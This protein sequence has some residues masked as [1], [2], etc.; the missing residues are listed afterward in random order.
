DE[1]RKKRRRLLMQGLVPVMKQ[2]ES[3]AEIKEKNE[4]FERMNDKFM[5]KIWKPRCEA[6]AEWEKKRN[7]KKVRKRKVDTRDEDTKEVKSQR[8]RKKAIEDLHFGP[9]CHNWWI[10][11]L[12]EKNNDP[13]F[14]FPIRLQSKI[15]VILNERD[16]IIEVGQLDSQ[17]GPHPSYTCKCD[18][19]QSE[20]CKTPT[21]TITTVYQ[22]IFK[23]KT[24]FSGPEV[25]GYDTPKIVQEYLK[26]LSF[27]VFNYS[28]NKL[29]IYGY[30]ELTNHVTKSLV[31]LDM[32]LNQHFE[33]NIY[34]FM[35]NELESVWNKVG[36]LKQFTG[37]QLFGLDCQSK[38]MLWEWFHEEY[39]DGMKRTS[40]YTYLQGGQYIS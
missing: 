6:V 25:M 38:D 27:R 22:Q 15:L 13:C 30:S 40:F 3:S 34:V 24:N 12:S 11:R 23:S 4:I 18:G 37:Y 2:K 20:L 8:K 17:F 5:E 32:D 19:I 33:N 14:L 7:I 35:D 29:Q 36:Y 21:E 31:L 26:E 9:F 16:F 10:S 1:D 28:L 39:P